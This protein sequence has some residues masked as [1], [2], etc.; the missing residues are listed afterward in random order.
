MAA[1]SVP[2]L[3]N[4]VIEDVIS[5]VREAFLDDGVD[6]QIILELKQIWE[7]KLKETKAIEIKEPEQTSH[8][9]LPLQ[10]S[11]GGQIVPPV[12]LQKKER[13]QTFTQQIT[14]SPANLQQTSIQYAPG[15]INLGGQKTLTLAMPQKVTIAIPGQ[16]NHGPIQ[17]VMS[18]PGSAATLSLPSEIVTTSLFPQ[19]ALNQGNILN[20]S[21]QL[22]AVLT[23]TNFFMFHIRADMTVFL[24]V[25]DI[26]ASY[27]SLW[28]CKFELNFNFQQSGGIIQLDGTN[29]T[30]DEDEEEDDDGFIDNEDNREEDDEHNDDENDAEEEEPL[31]SDDDDTEEDATELFYTENVV[32]CQYDK[33]G[34]SKNRWKFHLKD[35]IMNLKGKDYVFQKA[36]GDAEW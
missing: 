33:I 21:H 12:L 22:N 29:D 2:K 24:I 32:V 17:T 31:N 25:K 15:D 10:Q 23:L 18:V 20:P 13:N 8:V 27:N 11:S 16:M 4:S 9:L 14:L 30:S 1:S 34:R 6:E 7:K 28:M 35:G 3:Y 36:V 26:S 5:N 19:A